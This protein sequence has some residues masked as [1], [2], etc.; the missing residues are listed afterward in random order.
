VTATDKLDQPF[1]SEPSTIQSALKDEAIRGYDQMVGTPR[2]GGTGFSDG[3]A[4]RRRPRRCAMT[5]AGRLLLSFLV[6]VTLAGC[7]ALAAYG[8]ACPYAED[9]GRCE[10]RIS[11]LDEAYS[12]EIYAERRVAV[13]FSANVSV[14][15]GRV[16]VSV[17]SPNGDVTSVVA[18]PQEPAVFEGMAV[19]RSEYFDV[20]FEP[21]DGKAFGIHFVVEYGPGARPG[22][23]L[24]ASASR[25]P[26]TGT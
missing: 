14:E 15:Q 5:V 8:G 20:T 23:A 9:T 21:V 10:G 13:G 7:E 18:T 17:E 16:N 25:A 11:S 19:V 2:A 24:S 22:S 3:F 12:H 4:G 1:A 26:M 6:L